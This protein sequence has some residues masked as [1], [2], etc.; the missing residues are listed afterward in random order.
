MKTVQ[1]LAKGTISALQDCFNVAEQ[2][3]CAEG[4]DL[5]EHTSADLSYT[6]LCTVNVTT[7]KTLEVFRNQKQWLNS[8][9]GAQVKAQGSAFKVTCEE[10]RWTFSITQLWQVQCTLLWSAGKAASVLVIP[11]D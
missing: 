8:E 9:V 2:S 5:K 1:V 10:N 4:A 6:N 11:T 7:T 3:K